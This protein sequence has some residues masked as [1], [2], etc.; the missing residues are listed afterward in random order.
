MADMPRN[1]RA[2]P[3]GV[4][5]Q[6]LKNRP[7]AQ[8]HI[9]WLPALRNRVR[10]VPVFESDSSAADLEERAK[11]STYFD[12]EKK[13]SPHPHFPSFC[14]SLRPLFDYARQFTQLGQLRVDR[15]VSSRLEYNETLEVIQ[16]W[17]NSGRHME[18]GVSRAENREV[19]N[20]FEFFTIFYDVPIAIGWFVIFSHIF[21]HFF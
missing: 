20:S 5:Q 19:T 14:R 15:P 9:R 17:F 10:Q 3:Q 7:R 21:D 8:A 16:T 6:Q 2:A 13:R 12:T 18:A 1:L 11:W 4:A